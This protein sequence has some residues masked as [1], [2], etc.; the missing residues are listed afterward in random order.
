[1]ASP[2]SWPV[3]VPCAPSVLRRRLPWALG[4]MFE[5]FLKVG[6][7]LFIAIWLIVVTFTFFGQRI[8]TYVLHEL[9]FMGTTFTKDKWEKAGQ[10]ARGACELDRSCARGGM[11]R[12]LQRNHLAIGT[13][14]SVV[15][16]KIGKS[17]EPNRNSCAIYPL[18][19]CSGIG[20]DMDY[21]NICYNNEGR[22]ASVSHYQS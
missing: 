6:K 12:D 16:Q 15:E 11:Y 14:R 7:W 9:P 22:I 10:C 19:M 2:F 4:T 13:P 8:T 21:L 18:G 20:I 3:L 17:S 1:M 5:A